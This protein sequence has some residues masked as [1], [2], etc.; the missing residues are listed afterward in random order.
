MK[1]FFLILVLFFLLACSNSKQ[2]RV[3]QGKDGKI[4]KANITAKCTHP[5]KTY[6]RDLEIK[7]KSDMDSLQFTP[8]ASFDASFIQKV[9]K[10]HDYS[11][12]G[13]DLDLLTFRICE[14]ANNRGMTAEQT[15]DLLKRAMDIWNESNQKKNQP[16]QLAVSFNQQGGITANAIYLGKPNI[17]FSQPNKIKLL[18]M[19]PAKDKPILISSLMGNSDSFQLAKEISNFLK[20]SGYTRIDDSGTFMIS[21]PIIGVA[22]DSSSKK[23]KYEIMVGYLDA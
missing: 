21:P 17:N 13:L 20:L 1:Q 11:T 8:E 23:G 19:L 18:S 15:S 3:K 14:M 2:R 16:Q 5:P 9:I 4:Q 10:L 7:L 22:I 12:Q 6:A